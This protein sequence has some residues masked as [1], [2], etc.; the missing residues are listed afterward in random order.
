MSTSE[1]PSCGK[2][3]ADNSVLPAK[4]GNLIA[5]MAENLAVHMDAL[6][7][8]DQNSQAEH[9]AYARLVKELRQT[10]IQL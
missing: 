7:L 5:A 2:G 1:Q 4:L 6:D 10:A 9:D 3:L 8:T